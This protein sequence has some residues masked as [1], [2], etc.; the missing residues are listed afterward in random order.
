MSLVALE[1]TIDLVLHYQRYEDVDSLDPT[2]TEL[3]I[4]FKHIQNWEYIRLEKELFVEVL[5]Y[6]PYAVRVYVDDIFIGYIDRVNS[7]IVHLLMDYTVTGAIKIE[8]NAKPEFVD[9]V[10]KKV[11]L[12]IRVTTTDPEF[13][14]LL[15]TLELK[16]NEEENGIY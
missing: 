8:L 12:T 3:N 9:N 10:I 14:S 2:F 11:E 13:C 16:R 1:D 5:N 7:P 4:M 15:K 6:D